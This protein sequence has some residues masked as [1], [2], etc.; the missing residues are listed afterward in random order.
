MFSPSRSG[1]ILEKVL[2]VYHQGVWSGPG[3]PESEFSYSL[4]NNYKWKETKIQPGPW[5][6]LKI[7]GAPKRSRALLRASTQKLASRV[8]E[9]SQDSTQRLYQSRMATR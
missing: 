4:S 1:Q 5:S 7:S 8:F 9:S 3:S 2:S 6:D